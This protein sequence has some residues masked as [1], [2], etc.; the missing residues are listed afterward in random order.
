MRKLH[1]GFTLFEIAIVFVIGIAITTA[2]IIT[3]SRLQ[4]LFRLRTAADE[5]RSQIQYGRELA[6]ANKDQSL[7]GIVLSG[8]IFRLTADGEDISR[9]QIPSSI[10]V[11]PTSMLWNFAPVTGVV[12]SCSPCQIE[13]TRGG[14]LESIIIQSNGIVN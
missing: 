13:L 5:M 12:Q 7:Y 4:S 6:I 8:N 11:S 9:Y 10:I 14:L 2:G 3:L 1:P